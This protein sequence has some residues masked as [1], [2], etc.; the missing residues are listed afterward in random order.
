MT[1]MTTPGRR[2]GQVFSL[3]SG[4]LPE[5]GATLDFG[6]SGCAARRR[7]AA[8]PQPGEHALG[9]GH[10]SLRDIS[11]PDQ[12]RGGWR[13]PL[14]G[15]SAYFLVLLFIAA[16]TDLRPIFTLATERP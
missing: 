16:L 6:G 12:L 3:V 10:L 5:S 4:A 8:T 1:G 9:S 11:Q 14:P 15:D 2:R 13:V 7:Q